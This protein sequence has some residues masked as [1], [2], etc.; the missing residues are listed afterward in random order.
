MLPNH[1]TQ[2]LPNLVFDGSL[3]FHVVPLFQLFS[4]FHNC[5][6][7]DDAKLVF[8]LLVFISF[9]FHFSA[10][11]NHFE[12]CW[13]RTFLSNFELFLG[14]F[15]LLL[16]KFQLLLS[17]LNYFW[18]NSNYFWAILNKIEQ[19][20]P[21]PTNIFFVFRAFLSNFDKISYSQHM[22]FF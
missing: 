11:L 4:V 22:W 1:A 19:D 18:A 14:I 21:G 15:E 3:L 20:W 9:I 16:S 12:T 2:T 8:F 10:F 17:N 5:E 7:R 6:R 13:A